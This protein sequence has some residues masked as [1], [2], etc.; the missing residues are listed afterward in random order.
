MPLKQRYQIAQPKIRNQNTTHNSQV[1]FIRKKEIYDKRR[2]ILQVANF[3][4]ENIKNL[5][6]NVNLK[7]FRKSLLLEKKKLKKVHEYKLVW[8]K[9]GEIYAKKNVKF[10]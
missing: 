3:E 1:Y 4:I 5:Y 10:K 2:N 8:T 7:S 9:M 6:I